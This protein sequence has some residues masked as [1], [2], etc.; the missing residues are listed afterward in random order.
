MQ[1]PTPRLASAGDEVSGVHG[2]LGSSGQQLPADCCVA[3]AMAGT[4]AKSRLTQRIIRLA[5]RVNMM[6]I[7][8]A[9]Y[10][11]TVMSLASSTNYTVNPSRILQSGPHSGAPAQADTL[12]GLVPVAVI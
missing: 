8:L 10:Q 1:H 6:N 7:V 11:S 2:A 12:A 4:P 9:E 3:Q 5:T